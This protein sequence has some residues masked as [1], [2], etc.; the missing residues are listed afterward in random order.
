MGDCPI[1]LESLK[2]E[3][4]YVSKCKHVFHNKCIDAWLDGNVSCPKCRRHVIPAST[5]D[6]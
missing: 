5:I 4:N 2:D 3:D 1:C 6:S